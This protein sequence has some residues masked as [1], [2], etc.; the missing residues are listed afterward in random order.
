[1]KIGRLIQKIPRPN[2]CTLWVLG[3]CWLFYAGST[4]EQLGEPM[5]VCLY[6]FCRGVSPLLM[7]VAFFVGVLRSRVDRNRAHT[8]ASICGCLVARVWVALSSVL[9]VGGS[10]VSVCRM[11]S[12]LPWPL[13]KLEL[14]MRE[15]GLHKM[16][17]MVGGT[18]WCMIFLRDDW[19]K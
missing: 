1:M 7:H 18:L 2:R 14:A 15:S 19:A 12:N 5:C 11:T 8:A 16:E 13:W 17:K 3:S 10:G 4:S 9:C 6:K